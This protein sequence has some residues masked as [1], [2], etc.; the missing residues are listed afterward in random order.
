[1]PFDP[2]RFAKIVEE[3]VS[4]IRL[5]VVERRYA[6]FR[7]DR[8]YGGI[9]TGDVVGCNLRCVFCWASTMRDHLKCK[10]FYCSPRKAYGRLVGIASSRGF[11]KVRLS[12]G[13]PTIAWEH[14][15]S[16]AELIVKAGLRFVLETNG[17][18]IGA[19]PEIAQDIAEMEGV[20][21]RVSI[22]AANPKTFEKLTGARREFFWMQLKALENLLEAG[23][24]PGEEFYPAIMLSFNDDREISWLEEKIAS[25]DPVLVEYVDREYV[26]MYPRVR[27]QLEEAGIKPRKYYSPNGIPREMV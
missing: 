11:F 18:L 14:A 25:I 1:M 10:G 9:A 23:L 5:G 2:V 27:R 20:V 17:I 16:V 3:S 15:K 4:R 12:G 6:R 7:G 21:V 13:E 26:I 19:R 8:W 24:V 22:K